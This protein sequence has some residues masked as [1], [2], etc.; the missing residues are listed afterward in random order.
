MLGEK[1][2]NSIL[3][4]QKLFLNK[5]NFKDIKEFEELHNEITNFLSSPTSHTSPSTPP[6]S[7]PR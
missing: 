6:Q 7:P 4:I 2:S 5:I 3:F 1:D